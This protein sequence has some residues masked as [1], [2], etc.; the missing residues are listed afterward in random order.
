M[1]AKR[2]PAPSARARR[3]RAVGGRRDVWPWALKRRPPADHSLQVLR[4]GLSCSSL[5]P[6]FA[7][8]LTDGL[9]SENSSVPPFAGGRRAQ[10]TAPPAL[11]ALAVECDRRTTSQTA[12]ISRTGRSLGGRDDSNDGPVAGSSETWPMRTAAIS[13]A[14]GLVL[15]DSSIAVLA[16]PALYRELGVDLA[17]LHWVLTTFNVALALAAIPA[18]R[19]VRS[20]RPGR[21]FAAG[22]VLFAVAS[23]ACA[24]APSFGALLAFRAVQALGGAAVVVA[25]LELLPPLVRSRTRGVAV[26]VGAGAV[27][28]AVGPAVGGV[29]TEVI[30]WR[31]VFAVQV[32]LALVPLGL[33]RGLRSTLVP[34]PKSIRPPIAPNIALALVSAALAAPLFLVVLLLVEG[35]GLSPIAAASAVS[36]LPLAAVVTAPLVRHVRGVRERAAAGAILVA[37]G[38]GGLALLPRAGW[39]WTLPPQALVGA[40]LALAI[41]AVT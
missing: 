17:D 3:S 16:L 30:S 18:A 4:C 28:A 11:G 27:G 39:A 34:T 35:W 36:V 7:V 19:I 32:P 5:F 23:A 22:L 38:L 29:L 40:G 24:A 37:G 33:V 6:R 25:A 20:L 15:A 14:V 9:K 10:R 12:R 1:G 21:A 26:W 13:L 8:F 31:A 2:W 41:T